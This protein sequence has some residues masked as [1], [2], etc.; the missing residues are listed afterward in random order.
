MKISYGSYERKPAPLNPKSAALIQEDAS[1]AGGAIRGCCSH[2]A[3]LAMVLVLWVPAIVAGTQL[4]G[5][6]TNGNAAN[7]KAAVV[8]A[9]RIVFNQRCEICHFSD[10]RAKKIGPG[11]K[12]LFARARLTDGNRVTDSSVAGVI[13]DGGKNMPG[14]GDLLKPGQIQALIAYLKSH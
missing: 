4:P 1:R 6:K 11:L 2:F 14:Y 12:D 10:S 5:G 7:H 9:G 13:T 3:A 8:D